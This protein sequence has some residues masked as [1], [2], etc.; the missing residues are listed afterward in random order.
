MN[1]P[2]ATVLVLLI[3]CACVGC[4]GS[5]PPSSP[6][7]LNDTWRWDGSDW[8]ALPSANA[9]PPRDQ[10]A[11]VYDVATNQMTLFGGTDPNT[12]VFL[13]DTWTWDGSAWSMRH[14][15]HSPEPRSMARM[16]YDPA[17]KAVILVGGF[18]IRTL[19][20]KSTL[21]AYLDDAWMWDGSDW[22]AYGHLPRP[23]AFSGADQLGYDPLSHQVVAVVAVAPA[24]TAVSRSLAWDGATWKES[25][26]PAGWEGSDLLYVDPTSGGLRALA[27]FAAPNFNL[28]YRIVSFSGGLWTAGPEI[29][30]PASMAGFLNVAGAAY[31][32]GHAQIVTF[33][34]G[35]HDHP[36]SETWVFDGASWS[37]AQPAHRPPARNYTYLILD[38]SRN[39]VLMFGGSPQT[40]VSCSH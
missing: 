13:N 37:M 39:D 24:A 20:D 14:P 30:L 40:A 7:E 27:D 35:C 26:L 16:V 8:T 38:P 2:S 1:R 19:P 21:L 36:N 17:I 25:A 5:S 15:Q 31:D 18:T 9:P 23:V 29:P 34:G 33:G 12:H 10:G 3:V 32:S 22:T 11:I 4:G 6:R 28:T